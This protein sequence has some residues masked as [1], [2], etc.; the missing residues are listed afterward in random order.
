MS[1]LTKAMCWELVKIGKDKVNGVGVAI[2]R[3]PTSNDCYE[4]RMQSDP[5]MCQESDGS[6][7][8]W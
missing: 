8:V 1:R 2:Y 5:P 6:N 4:N 7:S 3:K